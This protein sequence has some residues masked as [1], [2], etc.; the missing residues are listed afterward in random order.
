MLAECALR[1]EFLSRFPQKSMKVFRL[2]RGAEKEK[3]HELLSI[4]ALYPSLSLLNVQKEWEFSSEEM[5]GNIEAMK[6]HLE[7]EYTAM[8]KRMSSFEK[9]TSEMCTTAERVNRLY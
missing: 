7:G 2:T 8:S 5:E 9:D 4:D 6:A 1:V 3:D